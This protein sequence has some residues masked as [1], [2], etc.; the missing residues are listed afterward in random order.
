MTL[1]Q[2]NFGKLSISWS[3]LE[4]T[5]EGANR[6]VLRGLLMLLLA[7]RFTI[8]LVKVFVRESAL[9]MFD[10]FLLNKQINHIVK[11]LIMLTVPF[12]IRSLTLYT[13]VCATVTK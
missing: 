8:Q 13:P 11:H 5:T 2:Q 6:A 1:I 7:S 3:S 10:A 9:K 12:M 4:R